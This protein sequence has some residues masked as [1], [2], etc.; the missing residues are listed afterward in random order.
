MKPNEVAIWS[1]AGIGVLTLLYFAQ[2]QTDERIV[3]A[4]QADENVGGIGIQESAGFSLTTGTPLDM[5]QHIHGW[6]P[7]YDPDPTGQP[8]THS[9]HR[10]PVVPGGNLSTVMHHGWGA[11]VTRAPAGN[12]W[13]T[14]PPEAAVL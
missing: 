10:Y 7:G 14:T 12:D 9:K 1:L 13:F 3:P 11:C 2:Q 4:I 8:V 6:H 5:S